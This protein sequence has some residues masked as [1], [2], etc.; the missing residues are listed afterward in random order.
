MT[1]FCDSNDARTKKDKR[2]VVVF[3]ARAATIMNGLSHE[4]R[5]TLLWC[6][7]DDAR[8]K[9]DKRAVVVFAARARQ[10]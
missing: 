4:L 9:K 6:D 8:T 10:P 7:S 2:A 3:A 1:C 5:A